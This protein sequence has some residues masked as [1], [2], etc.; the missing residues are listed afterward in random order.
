ETGHISLVGFYRRRALRLLPALAVLCG[1]AFIYITVVTHNTGQAWREGAFLTFYIGNWTR[2]G[3]AG[4]PQ[5][6]GHTWSLAIEEQFYMVWPLL[7]LGLFSL[8]TRP[9]FLVRVIAALV[10]AVLTWRIALLLNGAGAER[11][12]NGTD[13]RADSLLI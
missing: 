7:L 6:L 9:L 11:L 8:N 3:G 12:Y 5:Y 2:A 10:V 1:A 13:T 4:L